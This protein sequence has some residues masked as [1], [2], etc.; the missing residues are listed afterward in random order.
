MMIDL[1]LTSDRSLA[2]LRPLYVSNIQRARP[3]SEG[4][5]ASGWGYTYPLTETSSAETELYGRNKLCD[6]NDDDTV[7]VLIVLWLMFSVLSL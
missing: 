7:S 3:M 2:T 6:D 5:S 1:K 4:A